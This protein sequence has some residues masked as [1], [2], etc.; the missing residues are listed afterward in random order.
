MEGSRLINLI[1]TLRKPEI[2]A[3]RKFLRSPFFN[4]REDVVQLFQ[5]L[6]EQPVAPDKET[7]FAHLYPG[8]AYDAQQVRYAM[9][10]LLKL[11]E[12]YLALQPYLDDRFRMQLATVRA[13]R[14][15]QLPK[16][17]AQSLRQLQ[18]LQENQPLR[19]A[20]YY[21]ARFDIQLEQ[22]QFTAS[23]KRLSEHNLQEVSDSLDLA[24][25][26]KKL[27]QACLL[28]SHQAVYQ[29]DYDFG[30]L[31]T[32]IQ[33]IEE[34]ELLSIPALAVYYHCY[35]ALSGREADANFKAFLELLF[36]QGGLFPAHEA[37]DL[38][39]LA[40]NYCIRRLNEG[41]EN[42]A[43]EG[44]SLYKKG[45]QAGILAPGGNLS[46]FT[47]RNVVA[48]A[49]KEKELEWAEHFIHLY[50]ECLPRE[51]QESMFS[52]SLARLAYERRQYGQVLEWLQ[53]AEYEDLLLNLAAKTLL[54]KTY[55]EL[56]EEELL[57]SHLEAM[58]VFLRRK[59]IIGYHRL[60]YRNIIR[61]THQLLRLNS[62]NRQAAQLLRDKIEVETVLTEKAWLLAQ[63]AVS[64]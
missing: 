59:E 48:M 53:K 16:H 44:L 34:R 19:Q 7:V 57:E 58:K 60:N 31:D 33:Y 51:H 50:K 63:L 32:V 8:Q 49:L 2:R 39:L 45:L 9:S 56:G 4:Q 22:Y 24:F 35:F 42:Y 29:R 62:H 6:T 30:L 55:Y 23:Q 61:Y 10:W 54:L 1:A 28:R 26:A 15:R 11:I 14:E 37:R 18:Q 38:Y 52:F 27:R 20:E 46:R 64:S 36:Q 43:R 21:E 25:L 5:L 47:Y 3:L 41:E 17:F 12:Q 40:L 13:Y